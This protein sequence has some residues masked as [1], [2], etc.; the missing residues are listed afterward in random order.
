MPQAAWS[1][2][3]DAGLTISQS[4]TMG[5][6]AT[7]C[8]L[9]YAARVT[10]TIY[11]RVDDG[12]KDATD[13]YASE[14]GM[15]LASAVADLL[16]RGLQQA[17]DEASVRALQTRAFELRGEL[18]RAQDA[19]ATMEERL[20]QVIGTCQCGSPLTGRDLLLIGRCPKCNRGVASLLAGSTDAGSL[21]EGEF[22]P[23]LTGVGVALALLLLAYAARKE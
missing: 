11:A 5:V 16:D 10:S 2:R 13:A 9:P 15:S 12:L 20:R 18:A 3:W 22:V 1:Y 17:A 7:A 6:L 23:F 8:W 21:N 19:A 14:H 4:Q